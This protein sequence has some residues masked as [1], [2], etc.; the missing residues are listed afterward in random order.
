MNKRYTCKQAIQH[1]WISGNTAKDTNIHATVSEQLKKNFAKSH[2]KRAYNASAVIR[3][4]RKLG[5]KH[6]D[7][8]VP[9]S[10]VSGSCQ[11]IGSN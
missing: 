7:D 3:Q 10:A 6:F 4:L 5:K 1:P 9:L 11:P 8:S 2:W